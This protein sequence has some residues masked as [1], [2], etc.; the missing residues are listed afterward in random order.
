MPAIDSRRV[1]GEM[2]GQAGRG[3]PPGPFFLLD[4]ARFL[5]HGATSCTGVGAGCFSSWLT[6][7]F[8]RKCLLLAVLATAAG[9]LLTF[10]PEVEPAPPTRP[11]ASEAPAALGEPARVTTGTITLPTAKLE[12]VCYTPSPVAMDEV[13]LGYPHLRTDRNRLERGVSTEDRVYRTVVLENTYLKVTLLPAL[14]GRLFEAVFKPTGAQMFYR[15]Q[16]LR[17]YELWHCGKEWMFATGGLRFEFPTWGHDANTEQPWACTTHTGPDGSASATF[18]RT[19]L[20]TGLCLRMRVSL[21]AGRTWI[22]LNAELTNPTDHAERAQVWVISGLMGTRGIEFIMPVDYAIEHGGQHTYR[23][24][25][26]G[27]VDWS[28]FRNWPRM[29][30]FFALDWRSD[31]SGLYDHD[32]QAGV[33][34][35]V[36]PD[37]AP[38][39]KLW[40]AP[41]SMDRYYVSLYGGITQTMEEKIP[42]APGAR[43]TWEEFWYPLAKTHGLTAATREVALSL[44]TDGP[45]LLLGV[46]PTRVHRHASVHVVRGRTV[47]RETTTD[48]SPEQA[49]VETIDLAGDAETLTV[50]VTDARGRVLIDRTVEVAN[51][52][53]AFKPEPPG[54]NP[55]EGRR[56]GR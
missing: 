24:P 44:H 30:A 56:R 49:L 9:F 18:A 42:L 54:E 12:H 3:L 7:A 48:L 21:D 16:T 1:A 6:G 19:D 15:A 51:I 8:L 4:L 27:G 17:P 25:V 34:R 20:A 53:P 2:F 50:R 22:R 52:R 5:T 33:V 14:G 46:M 32:A 31:F 28:Y 23:W 10:S 13:D 47:L 41:R 29:Q 40:G 38:G 45:K 26:A 11:I 39:I 43:K 37:D 55:R 36:R 35:W